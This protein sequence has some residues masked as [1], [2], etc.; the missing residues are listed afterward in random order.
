MYFRFG[1][2]MRLIHSFEYL[3][4]AMSF[5][6]LLLSVLHYFL[7]S[8]FTYF[9]LL[10]TQVLVILLEFCFSP[11]VPVCPVVRGTRD[12]SRRPGGPVGRTVAGSVYRRIEMYRRRENTSPPHPSHLFD[13]F[14]RRRFTSRESLRKGIVVTQNPK[15]MNTKTKII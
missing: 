3:D 15:S 11:W 2:L 6:H 4:L 9:S 10:Q 14:F 5:L 7:R 13:Y 1:S 8:L 12:R